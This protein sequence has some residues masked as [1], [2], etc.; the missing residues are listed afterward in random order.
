MNFY[1]FYNLLNE[2]TVSQELK[3]L[4]DKQGSDDRIDSL[5]TNIANVVKGINDDGYTFLSENSKKIIAKWLLY[6]T[7]KNRSGATIGSYMIRDYLTANID[8]N[9]NLNPQLASKFNSINFTSEDLIALDHQY[10]ENLKKK[11]R[12]K[13]GEIGKNILSF[14]DGYNWVDLE[15]SYCEKES[16]SMGH[17]GNRGGSGSDTILSLRDSK[18][19]PHLTFILNKGVLGEMKGRNNDKPQPKYHPY[20]TELL[21]LPII[22]SVKGGGYKPENNFKLSDLKADQLQSL[23]KFKPELEISLI[24]EKIENNEK[25]NDN[26]LFK[27]SDDE[28][29]MVRGLIIKYIRKPNNDYAIA[30]RT[31]YKNTVPEQILEKLSNDSNIGIRGA[32][33]GVTENKEILKKLAKD[34]SVDVRYQVGSNYHTPVSV[35]KFLSNDQKPL[36]REGVATNINT[37]AEILKILK[38]DEEYNVRIA[39]VSNP[40]VSMEIALDLMNDKDIAVS[41][42]AKFKVAQNQ[43]ASVE[44]LKTIFF[45]LLRNQPLSHDEV[46]LFKIIIRHPN[47]SLDTLYLWTDAERLSF[48]LN[49]ELE[50]EIERRRK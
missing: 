32:V 10:H 18:N 29:P 8:Q 20:I 17:C 28:D 11:Q 31:N 7:I 48:T 43:D 39:V 49:K 42:K 19:I 50:Q 46:A 37:P 45:E 27:I 38:N 5:D 16:S 15:K 1:E 26:E 24:I 36:V 23:L 41:T 33:A 12:N 22:K 21:R 6:Q 47:V 9:G 13:P 34:N 44:D 35:L 25:L 3:K 40:N 30:N 4:F 14:P 2:N